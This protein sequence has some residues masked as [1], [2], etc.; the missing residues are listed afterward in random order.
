MRHIARFGLTIVL[1][2]PVL[3][4]AAWCASYVLLLAD[5]LLAP[6]SPVRVTLRSEEGPVR[7]EASSFTFDPRRG[8]LFASHVTVRAPDG[9]ALGSVVGLDV[10]LPGFGV[11]EGLRVVARDAEGTLERLADGS[12]RLQRLLPRAKTTTTESPTSV[13]IHG[14]RLAYLDRSAAGAPVGATVT[15][16]WGRFEAVGDQWVATVQ[17]ARVDDEAGTVSGQVVVSPTAVSGR[18][19]V[20]DL[21]AVGWVGRLGRIPEAAE[22]LKVLGDWSAESLVADASFRFDAPA[23]GRLRIEGDGSGTVTGLIGEGGR[24]ADR[25]VATGRFTE[26][27]FTGVVDAVHGG[28]RLG[29]TGLVAWDPRFV[30]R[31]RTVVTSRTLHDLP[32]M[33][34]RAAPADLD[35]R[36]GKAVGSLEYTDGGRFVGEWELA[37]ASVRWRGE[38][39]KSARG[40]IAVEDSELRALL[41]SGEWLGAPVSGGVSLSGGHLGGTVTSQAVSLDRLADR[42]GVSGLTGTAAVDVTLGG[43]PAASQI[44]FETTGRAVYTNKA[45]RKP[46]SGRFAASGEWV[47]KRLRLR[48]ANVSGN[49]G[50]LS[51][52]GSFR[53]PDRTPK[54]WQ[55]GL[56]GANL[57]FSAAGLDLA[58]WTD[59]ATGL[60]FARGT[61]TT[62]D[63]R[64]VVEGRIEGYEVAFGDRALALV[65]TPFELAGE[66]LR[67]SAIRAISEAGTLDATLTVNTKRGDLDGYAVTGPVQIDRFD[68]RVIGDVWLD[69]AVIGGTLS[70]PVFSGTVRA[71]GVRFQDVVLESASAPVAYAGG[72]LTMDGGTGVMGGGTLGLSGRYALDSRVGSAK[73]VLE[74]IEPM[75]WL[76][77]DL[78]RGDAATSLDGTIEAVVN[79]DAP[80]EVTGQGAFRN[81]S[82]GGQAFDDGTWSFAGLGDYWTGAMRLRS[83]EEGFD[84]TLAYFDAKTQEIEARLNTTDFPVE[85]AVQAFMPTLSEESRRSFT[86]S[87]GR[88]TGRL[89]T[90]ATLKGPL[91]AVAF[92]L[93][94][95]SLSQ[96]TFRDQPLGLFTAKANRTAA[97][98][99]T[100]DGLTWRNDVVLPDGVDS[101][102]GRLDLRGTLR[103]KG[104]IEVDGEAN[105][106]DLGWLAKVFPGLPRLGGTADLSLAASGTTDTPIARAS[107]R[108]SNLAL[109]P[110]DGQPDVAFG[111][112][113][114]T[115]ELVGRRLNVEGGRFTYRGITGELRSVD[116][117]LTDRFDISDRDP[118]SARVELPAQTI[119]NVSDWFPALRIGS[120]GATTS[121][122]LNMSRERGE[123]TV[124]GEA[125]LVSDTLRAEPGNLRLGPSTTKLQVQREPGKDLTLTGNLAAVG[126]GNLSG[127]ARVQLRSPFDDV[128]ALL[129]DP[130]RWRDLPIQGSVTLP[131]ASISFN[132][133]N[134]GAFTSVIGG[135]L[136]MGGTVGKPTISGTLAFRN[137]FFKL[138]A[139]FAESTSSTPP[140]IDPTFD[141]VFET[142][143][144]AVVRA[145]G[146]DVQLEGAG[147]LKSSLSSPRFE[148]NLGILSGF[149]QLPTGRLVLE[150]DRGSVD[151]LYDATRAT[152][153]AQVVVHDAN[154]VTY[155]TAPYGDD[156]ERYRVSLEID[157][158]LLAYDDWTTIVRTRSDPDGLTRERILGI[159]G[160]SDFFTR[161]TVRDG[162]SRGVLG[163]A[164]TRFALPS[165][166]D[167]LTDRIA[168]TIGLDYLGVDYNS[169]QGT[170][171]T[172]AKSFG[173]GLVLQAR[174]QLSDP[175]DGVRRF[176][177]RLSYR[178]PLRARVFDRLTL[179]FGFDQ[180]R[181]WKIALQYSAR[182]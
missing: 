8:R 92:D 173:N 75:R 85:R 131:D 3:G 103:E 150:K 105:N 25:A 141:I 31:G 30:A 152:R 136:P 118:I 16:P 53:I 43:T 55:E 27:S 179:S 135:D 142:F 5:R 14:L 168:R 69:S 98:F 108:T 156:I 148:A 1:W 18:G 182:L 117:T 4:L 139:V 123:W 37:S 90:R 109:R 104:A 71:Q 22:F 125:N 36:D 70:E 6:G 28:S 61:V 112:N 165:L 50:T 162:L 174:R 26:G 81:A 166:L 121:G 49:F 33:L 73:I 97:G 78:R 95:L 158:D 15:A 44:A 137:A 84:A 127:E 119:E 9:Q 143:G 54:G 167:P 23:E 39:L 40:T 161:L 47:G 140:S 79:G 83:G 41:E 51:G 107:L 111:L 172:V 57:A 91:D 122:S 138:P 13:E 88:V 176:D 17:D 129:D 181:P 134:Y 175:V 180:L 67:L 159:L 114:D 35:I 106:V 132:D 147:S 113:V 170:S 58:L 59:R 145:A 64:P 46:L 87:L 76:P 115:I 60:G 154:A 149:V 128:A 42:F 160:Q 7:V 171:A 155:L 32:P 72:V 63:G 153:P 20:V 86:D 146:A 102:L 101:T 52:N 10:A 94:A 11:R 65:A 89:T 74:G 38:T 151:V 96:A 130:G 169:F 116:A 48:R 24:Q 19:S 99:W 110:G 12:L 29:W 144:P 68:D 82:V 21:E 34:A 66:D 45:A 124:A 77:R 126:D 93:Q 157:G 62:R 80:L 133:P 178:L 120:K 164:L 2:V 177:V 163:E 56:Q 100:L